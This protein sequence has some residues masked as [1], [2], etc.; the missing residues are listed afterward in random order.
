MKA[1]LTSQQREALISEHRKERDRKRGDR[2]K[3]VLWSDEGV[4][5]TE[6]ARRLF[7][8]FD[9]VHGYIAAYQNEEGRLNPN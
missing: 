2:I 4:S 7:I 3:V 6:I 1:F 8:S 9:A 5:Q